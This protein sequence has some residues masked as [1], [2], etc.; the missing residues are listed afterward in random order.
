M[1]RRIRLAVIVSIGV[2]VIWLALAYRYHFLDGV[3]LLVH[4]AGHMILAPFGQIMSVLGGTLLQLAVPLAFVFY[5][6]TRSQSFEAGVC[7]VWAAESAMY[8]AEYMADANALALPLI[9]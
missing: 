6:R 7:G 5:F 9:G 1:T 8:T 3:N 2:Y 4:E